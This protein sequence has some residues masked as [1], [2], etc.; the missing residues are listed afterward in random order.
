[1]RRVLTY[2]GVRDGDVSVR[3]TS[4]GA[5]RKVDMTPDGG[6]RQ[7]TAAHEFGHAFGLDD[8]YGP[9]FRPGRPPTGSLVGH[10]EVKRDMTEPGD[11]TPGGAIV[12]NNDT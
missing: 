8:E 2:H 5:A 11:D 9:K 3:I 1:V 6:K 10:D 4:A 12:E 7:V